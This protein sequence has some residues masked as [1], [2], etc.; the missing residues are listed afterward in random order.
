MVYCEVE[1]SA[2]AAHSEL[3]ASRNATKSEIEFLNARIFE[4]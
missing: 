4:K 1:W 2:K 3:E